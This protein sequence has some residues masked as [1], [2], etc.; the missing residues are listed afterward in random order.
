MTGATFD[1]SPDPDD[2][3]VNSR[4][5]TVLESAV[6]QDGGGSPWKVVFVCPL[7]RPHSATIVPAGFDLGAALA[8]LGEVVE[9]EVGDEVVGHDGDPV[10][11]G[12]PAPA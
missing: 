8:P 10:A 4:L 1:T 11:P 6:L 9:H 2:W 5:A 12:S 7:R 3:N